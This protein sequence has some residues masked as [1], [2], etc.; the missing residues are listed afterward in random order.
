MSFGK[1]MSKNIG[2]NISKNLSGRYTEKLVDHAK[3]FAFT[4]AFGVVLVS[5]LLT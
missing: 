1:N 5:L 2:K 4:T 3:Q